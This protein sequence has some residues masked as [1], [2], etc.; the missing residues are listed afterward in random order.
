MRSPFFFRRFFLHFFFWDSTVLVAT[1]GAS[2]AS[3][4]FIFLMSKSFLISVGLLALYRCSRFYRKSAKKSTRN[5]ISK[6]EDIEVKA[7]PSPQSQSG[8][9]PQHA[10]RKKLRMQQT[11]KHKSRSWLICNQVPH[12][13]LCN[14][15][16]IFHSMNHNL[17]LCFRGS[18]DSRGSC[19][20]R[21]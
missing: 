1:T 19:R 13:R 14:F 11:C 7:S 20:E 10:S 4:Y 15:T 16:V 9:R 18:A 12:D 5:K 21:L 8:R 6:C 17:S 2:Q 3:Y